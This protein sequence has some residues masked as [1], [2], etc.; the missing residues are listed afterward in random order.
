VP[1]IIGTPLITTGRSSAFVKHRMER[2]EMANP[3]MGNPRMIQRAVSEVLEQPERNG[4][5]RLTQSDFGFQPVLDGRALRSKKSLLAG[6]ARALDFPEYFGENWDALEE[7]LR[8]MS[9]RDGQISLLIEHADSIPDALFATLREVFGQI[10]EQWATEGRV[11]S[12]FL[13]GLEKTD[14]P[15]LA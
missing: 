9:W 12:L 11:C 15:L 2:V 8:D 1:A 13:C 14:I 10:A 7:C 5:Y 4:I 6:I 3:A